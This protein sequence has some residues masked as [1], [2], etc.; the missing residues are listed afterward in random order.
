MTEIRNVF[1]ESRL[2]CVILKLL[3][4][5]KINH[6][7]FRPAIN[8]HNEFGPTLFFFRRLAV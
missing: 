7:L 6:T 4:T 2:K 1:D 5:V 8:F 3:T